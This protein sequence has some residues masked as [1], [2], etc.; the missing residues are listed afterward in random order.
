M[1]EMLET[2]AIL[3]HA[4][5]RSLIILDEIGRGTGTSMAWRSPA[6]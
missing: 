4:T 6:P 3:H 1:V 2:A 5:P